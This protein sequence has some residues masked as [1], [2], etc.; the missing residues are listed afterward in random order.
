MSIQRMQQTVRRP[1][2]V[3]GVGYW[4]GQN[5]RVEFRPAPV[6]SGLTFV[7]DDIGPQARV[8]AL[9]EYR[10]N[11]PRRT[12]LECLG[13]EVQMVEHVLAA[14]AGLQVDNCEIGVNRAEMPGCDG[15]A[16]E[17]VEALDSVGIVEQNQEASQLTIKEVVRVTSGEAWIEARPA[18]DGEYRIEFRLDYPHNPEIGLQ[19]ASFEITPQC[20]RDEIAPCRTFVL[21]SEAEAIKSQGLGTHVTTKELLVFGD[22]GPIEN[23]L[24]FENE[25]AR[26]KALDVIGDLALINRRI[27]G[28]IVA[29][30]S[31][32]RLH[33][34]LA[35]ELMAR[36]VENATLQATA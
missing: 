10:I 9:P 11:V 29:N 18:L 36:F 34:E 35:R 20:F 3:S 25:C 5:V 4:S 27:A 24:R 16:R 12:N 2:R 21:Q 19:A 22:R 17:F 26:H 7:R 33:V 15:S 28:N 30:R 6:G 1:V 13:V 14:L 32:H 8:P 31:G 23:Q